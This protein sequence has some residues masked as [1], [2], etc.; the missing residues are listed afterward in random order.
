MTTSECDCQQASKFLGASLVFA[1]LNNPPS[2]DALRSMALANPKDT[3]YV[4]RA[5]GKGRVSG[6]G[7]LK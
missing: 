6:T 4:V 3:P 2:D 7:P 1:L 5:T